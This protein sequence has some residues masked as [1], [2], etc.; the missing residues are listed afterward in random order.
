[1]RLA[2][3]YVGQVAA[4]REVALLPHVTGTLQRQ[5]FQDGARVRA[6]DLLFVIDPRPFQA[7]L[8]QARAQLAQAESALAKARQDVARFAPLVRDR[9]LP[10][11]TLDDARAARRSARASVQAQRA[12]VE[13][14]RLELEA[15]F[16][17]GKRRASERLARARAR[18][19]ALQ[20]RAAV[21][22]ALRDVSDAL[23]EAGKRREEVEVQRRRVAAA[24]EALRLVQAQFQAGVVSF[25]E[26]LD[27]QRALYAAR[28]DL[29]SAFAARQVGVVRLYQAL[30]GGWTAAPRP[31]APPAP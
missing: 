4:T 23:V 6:G 20:Y 14:A 17:G 18:E 7:A 3:E 2:Q 24:Q 29:A 27:G 25:L 11:Q 15:L 16:A 30:G 1:M 10:R 5:V 13:T 12:A 19:A 26:V 21:L 8:D 9:A 31:P 28:I 22:G